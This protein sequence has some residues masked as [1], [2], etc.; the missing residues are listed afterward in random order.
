MGNYII[1]LIIKIIKTLF[2][3]KIIKNLTEILY[4]KKNNKSEN[5]IKFP[6]YYSIYK[7]AMLPIFCLEY[8]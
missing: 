7:F 4:N 8:F 6:F 1:W 5:K 2:V 3:I